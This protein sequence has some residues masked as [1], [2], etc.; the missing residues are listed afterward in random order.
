MDGREDGEDSSQPPERDPTVIAFESTR[1]RL[2]DHLGN[3]ERSCLAVEDA[4]AYVL[5]RRPPPAAASTSADGGWPS[6][7]I[8]LSPGV[9]DDIARDPEFQRRM[10]QI[11]Y[12]FNLTRQESLDD[13]DDDDDD[14]YADG[15]SD[16]G[17][18]AGAYARGA[19]RVSATTGG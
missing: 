5:A 19:A 1:A 4:A 13:D 6:A 12:F 3:L 2:E 10:R 17:P 11:D 16:A 8:H 18:A 14:W 9:A 7:R 15:G